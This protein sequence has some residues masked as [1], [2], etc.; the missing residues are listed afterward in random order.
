M[1][2]EAL[3]PVTHVTVYQ[4]ILLSLT[5]THF[6]SVKGFGG[7]SI[8]IVNL[9]FFIENSENSHHHEKRL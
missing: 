8:K 9:V 1:I 3:P 6:P 2:S 7:L 4:H 5:A